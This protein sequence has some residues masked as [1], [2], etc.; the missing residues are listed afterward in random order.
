MQRIYGAK[1]SSQYGVE[2]DGTWAKGLAEF[3]EAEVLSALEACIESDSEWPPSLPQFRVLCRPVKRENEAMY[4]FPPDRQLPHL[5]TDEAR[6]TGRANL[7]K[8]RAGLTYGDAA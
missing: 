3:T 4:R 6:A 2:D 5:L 1:W 7:A 8:L